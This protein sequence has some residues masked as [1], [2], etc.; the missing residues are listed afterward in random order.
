MNVSSLTCTYPAK[1]T[2][3]ETY[4]LM[5]FCPNLVIFRLFSDVFFTGSTDKFV[6][7]KKKERIILHIENKLLASPLREEERP[8]WPKGTI[9]SRRWKMQSSK[10]GKGSLYGDYL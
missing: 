9:E 6:F 2:N 4:T 10:S 7:V 8:K 5:Q 3:G 1:F